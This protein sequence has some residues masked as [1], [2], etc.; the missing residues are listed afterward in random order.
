MSVPKTLT[1]D[2]IMVINY[3]KSKSLD[4][5]RYVMR[6]WERSLRECTLQKFMMDINLKYTTYR[7]VMIKN[8]QEVTRRKYTSIMSVKCY[9]KNLM[10][11]YVMHT[12]ADFSHCAVCY[13]KI[14]HKCLEKKCF[15]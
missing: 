6:T 11:I 1:Y 14:C 8:C 9:F 7:C 4:I 2:D 15:P 5:Q 3:G 12:G 13:V 10:Y